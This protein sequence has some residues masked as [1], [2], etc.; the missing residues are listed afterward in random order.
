MYDDK[1][2]LFFCEGVSGYAAAGPNTIVSFAVN[3]P[4]PDNTSRAQ[5]VNVRIAMPTASL[6]QGIDFLKNALNQR[7]PAMP[8][9]PTSVQ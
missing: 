8:P 6:E 7:S 3:I 4:S 9:G 1:A 5:R 2:P